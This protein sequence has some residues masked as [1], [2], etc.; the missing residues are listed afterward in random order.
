MEILVLALLMDAL[1]VV[2]E[3]ILTP[4]ER[5]GRKTP[6]VGREAAP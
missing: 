5:A 2:L 4:W 3:R 1:L 6:A